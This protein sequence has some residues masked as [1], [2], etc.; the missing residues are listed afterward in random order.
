MDNLTEEQINY[1]RAF[2]FIVVRGFITDVELLRREAEVAI[3]DATGDLFHTSE[4]G[5][6]EGH[7]T[8]YEREDAALSRSGY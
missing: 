7:Y 4:G 3:R 1:F 6:M 5:G 2:G 8:R